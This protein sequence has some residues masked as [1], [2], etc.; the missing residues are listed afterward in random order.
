MTASA[1]LRHGTEYAGVLLDGLSGWM[2]RKGFRTIDQLRGMLAVPVDTDQ[3][4]YER[5]GYVRALA[6]RQRPPYGPGNGAHKPFTDRRRPTR[7]RPGC[8]ARDLEPPV[9]PE[10]LRGST[11]ETRLV[12][13]EMVPAFRATS[14]RWAPKPP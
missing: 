11:D 12:T 5:A 6:S 3:A 9:A 4:D 13:S 1:L 7:W 2:A 10:L 8:A 14:C